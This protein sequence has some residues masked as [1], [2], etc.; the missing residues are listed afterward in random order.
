MSDDDEV[1]ETSDTDERDVLRAQLN[2]PTYWQQAVSD[3]RSRTRVKV[4]FILSVHRVVLS[5]R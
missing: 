2:D 5:K 3:F 4:T 1:I